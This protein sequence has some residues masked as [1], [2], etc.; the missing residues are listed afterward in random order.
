MDA[1]EGV[2]SVSRPSRLFV[3][4]TRSIIR[5]VDLLCLF[6]SFVRS[7]PGAAGRRQTGCLSM[8]SNSSNTATYRGLHIDVRVRL[9]GWVGRYPLVL[10]SL[11]LSPASLP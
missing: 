1:W 2:L 4:T 8:A 6:F 11:S 10:F 5:L 3:H 9:S 7:F